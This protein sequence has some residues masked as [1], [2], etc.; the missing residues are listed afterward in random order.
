MCQRLIKHSH[1]QWGDLL[2]L[3][4]RT[5]NSS[6]NFAT[7]T[8]P[9]QILFGNGLDLDRALLTAIPAGKEFDVSNYV[10][11]LAANQRI[12]IEE[13]DRVQSA[14]CGKIIA[15]A[16]AKQRGKP[17]RV[18]AIND[19]VLAKPQ[20]GFPMHKLAPRWLGP[21]RV[22]A[23]DRNSEKVQVL[24]V[25]SGK[26]RSFLKRQLELFDITRV[27]D[28]AGLTRVAELDRFEFP[29]EA[30]QGHALIPLQACPHGQPCHLG[31]IWGGR[32]GDATTHTTTT[33]SLLLHPPSCCSSNRW[34][35][36]QEGSSHGAVSE[37]GLHKVQ[38]HAVLFPGEVP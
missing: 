19:W 16:A 38:H 6:I 29:V 22:H 23:F 12:I 13:A 33:A 32:G 11:A 2:P 36:V 10:E 17:A 34:G 30:I 21:F 5:M 8:S 25:V 1:H 28:V 4:Q 24:D 3:V 37:C 7:G 20:P 9:A 31:L 15:K 14:V 27:S 35:N 18:L 26:I